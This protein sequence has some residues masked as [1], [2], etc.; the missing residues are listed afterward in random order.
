MSSSFNKWWPWLSS[1]R[2]QSSVGEGNAS[3]F[4][5]ESTFLHLF[6]S[7]FHIFSISVNYNESELAKSEG[8]YQISVTW[9]E[10]RNR[11]PCVYIKVCSCV[12]AGLS[13]SGDAHQIKESPNPSMSRG[14]ASVRVCLRVRRMCQSSCQV[15]T[16]LMRCWR[17]LT[18]GAH[19]PT[20]NFPPAMRSEVLLCFRG[21]F[22]H[23]FISHWQKR[24]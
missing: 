18:V 4:F 19:T 6:P 1:N 3:A 12:H 10:A 24:R 22:S 14:C 21:K 20:V 2:I 9:G 23:R 16:W 17:C 8:K 13:V 15:S 5:V 7:F 11:R